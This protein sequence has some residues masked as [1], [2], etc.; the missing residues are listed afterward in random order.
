MKN[1]L[2]IIN[3]ENVL[4]ILD[5]LDEYIDENNEIKPEFFE[6]IEPITKCLSI[7]SGKSV[8]EINITNVLQL[9][10]DF[11]NYVKVNEILEANK[12]VKRFRMR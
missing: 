5:I 7:F 11:D 6:K 3:F 2:E 1:K 8:E 12:L 4:E 9:V 10:V